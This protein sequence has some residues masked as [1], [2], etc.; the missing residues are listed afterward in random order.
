MERRGMDKTEEMLERWRSAQGVNFK[1]TE[2]EEA[3]K[4]R[5]GRIADAVQLKVPDRVPVLPSF[6]IFPALDN[7]FTSEECMFDYNKTFI[8]WMK[9]LAD[10]EPDAFRFPNRPGTVWEALDC[11]QLRLPGRGIPAYSNIQTVEGEWDTPEEFYDRFVEDPTDFILRV[12]LPNISR[13]LEPLKTLRP[14][15][16][17]FGYYLGFPG[18]LPS[19]GGPGVAEAFEKLCRAGSEAIEWANFFR[20]K[21]LE[22]MAMGF[23]AEAGMLATAPFD[24]IGDLIRGTRGLMLDMYRRPE[25]LMTAMDRL[26]PILIEMGLR[27]KESACPFVGMPLHRGSEGWMSEEQY[28]TFYWP[29][30]RK[31][32]MG[33][34]DEGI[35][36][37]LL[38]E[39]ENTSRLDIISDVPRG[40]AV[41]WFERVDLRRAKEILGDKVCFR[42]NVPGSLLYTGTPDDVKNYVKELIDVIG[43]NGGLIVD[44]GCIFDEARHE[45]VKAMVDFT[46][47]YGV[48]R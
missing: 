17:A 12:H 41:Y 9:T 23:P 8:A 21:S 10:F 44:S 11:K 36:P 46:K 47:E 16:H 24:V 5:A 35:V 13:V 32:M 15:R 31:V 28:R 42:G 37:V 22:V 1:D 48:Y 25:K 20:A 18:V 2:S 38:F 3:Y 43:E 30:L 27:A 14:I 4:R 29:P 45:N 6:G 33:L 7:G 26:V 40:K 34:I 19:F 39:G